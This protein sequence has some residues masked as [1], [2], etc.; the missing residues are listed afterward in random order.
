MQ[1]ADNGAGERETAGMNSNP[2]AKY[3]N[4]EVQY[5]NSPLLRVTLMLSNTRAIKNALTRHTD[6]THRLDTPTRHTDSTHRLDTPTRHTDSTHRLDT[7]TR[8]TDSTHRLDTPTHQ[9]TD[10]TH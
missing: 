9:Y 2:D 5:N 3:N 1:P 8:H 10:S 6:S 7:P 4:S